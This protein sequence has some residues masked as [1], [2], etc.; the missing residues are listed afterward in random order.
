MRSNKHHIDLVENFAANEPG[1]KPKHPNAFIS[2]LGFF[3]DMLPEIQVTVKKNTKMFGVIFPFN[4]NVI[5]GEVGMIRFLILLR[6][7]Y[8]ASLLR[9]IRIELH[10]PLESPILYCLKVPNE[11]NRMSYCD[12]PDS[13]EKGRVVR[14]KLDVR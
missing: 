14:K 2:N 3:F 6:E 13:G 7:N 1:K 5:E 9:Y 4:E 10:F 11:V 12:A 8:L